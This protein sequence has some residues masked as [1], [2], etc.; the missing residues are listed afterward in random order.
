MSEETSTESH[1]SVV[2]TTNQDDMTQT[3][4]VTS[5]SSRGAALYFECCVLVIGVIG[6][7]A[8]GLVL[9]ALVASKQQNKHELIF[10]QN[11]LDFYSCLVLVITYTMKLSNIQYTGSLGYWLCMFISSGN[12]VVCGLEGS[13]INLIFVAIERYLKV[14]HPIWS[15]KKLRKWMIYVAMAFAWIYGFGSTIPVYFETTV[16]I[17]GVCYAFVILKNPENKLVLTVLDWI[18]SYLAIILISVF[19]YWKILMAIRRQARVM[20]SHNPAGSSTAQTQLNRIQSSAI[21]T[22]ILVCAF[23]AITWLPE[24][25]LVLLIGLGVQGNFLDNGYYVALFFQFLYICTDVKTIT[26]QSECF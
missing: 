7:A 15:K 23:F 19:C 21:K 6:T 14:V 8:N 17:N 22:M 13:T 18:I 16:V 20:A 11:A 3:T 10:N 4:G 25:M 24:K 26:I 2:M 1:L 9:Y 12:L 5:S